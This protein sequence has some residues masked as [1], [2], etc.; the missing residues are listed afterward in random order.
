[1]CIIKQVSTREKV[2]LVRLLLSK[3]GVHAFVYIAVEQLCF[4]NNIHS[5]LIADV[6]RLTF[7][8]RV[9]KIIGNRL[10]F[11]TLKGFASCIGSSRD[12]LQLFAA[13][14]GDTLHYSLH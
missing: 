6:S 1:M 3:A 11:R 7:Q 8:T 5:I 2:T 10:T 9:R 4:C 14:V 13:L 12:A